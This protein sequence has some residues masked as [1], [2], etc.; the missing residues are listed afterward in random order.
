MNSCKGGVGQPT[1]MGANRERGRWGE[2]PQKVGRVDRGQDQPIGSLSARHSDW[3]FWS[4]HRWA[5]MYMDIYLQ[6]ITLLLISN[7]LLANF[8]Y[9][10]WQTK[11]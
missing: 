4:S 3:L 10:C 11:E 7:I 1:P 2:E 6:K 8:I 9:F 5:F